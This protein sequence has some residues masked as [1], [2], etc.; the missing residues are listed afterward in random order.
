MTFFLENRC[1]SKLITVVSSE[2]LLDQIVRSEVQTDFENLDFGLWL[3][4]T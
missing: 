2:E 4:E 3:Q 1:L